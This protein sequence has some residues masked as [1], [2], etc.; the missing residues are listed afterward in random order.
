VIIDRASLFD[1]TFVIERLPNQQFGGFVIQEL[2]EGGVP[3]GSM[4][5]SSPR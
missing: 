3:T 1:R 5:R 2:G 4:K